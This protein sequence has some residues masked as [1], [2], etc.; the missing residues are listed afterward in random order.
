MTSQ[1]SY[2]GD[3]ASDEPRFVWC[4]SNGCGACRVK[5]IEFEYE[6]T[7][8]TSGELLS[9]KTEPRLVSAC[10]GARMF[11]WDNHREQEI[12][13]DVDNLRPTPAT[14]LTHAA[15]A[16]PVAWIAVTDQMPEDGAQV[17]TLRPR[18]EWMWDDN[19]RYGMDVR[20]D[21]VWVAHN[22]A[23]E[24]FEAVGG[25]GAAGPGEV[26]TGPAEDAPYT[27]WAPLLPLPDTAASPAT[28]PALTHAYA[29]GRADEREE[30]QGLHAAIMN[31]PVA[32][33]DYEAHK[34]SDWKAGYGAGHH[35][36]RHTA[37]ELVSAALSSPSP[38]REEA[39]EDALTVAY[40]KGFSD[41][42]A[43]ASVREDARDAKR[44]RH[45]RRWWC[46][47]GTELITL[48]PE[49]IAAYE[50]EAEMDAAIDSAIEQMNKEQA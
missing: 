44:Y 25:A 41:G 14:S 9:S 11:M 36:A 43:A 21:G 49:G 26:C 17:M 1:P 13:V 5:R 18:E 19:E 16:E 3:A 35:D 23:R 12:D 2:S 8:S 50:T 30:A 34:S 38:A 48:M 42:K 33:A 31:L 32:Y 10:C 37:A 20:E 40:M 45:L 15:R 46:S 28:E 47:T 29:E 7:E 24:H 22:N 27:H 6:R 4:C 39:G